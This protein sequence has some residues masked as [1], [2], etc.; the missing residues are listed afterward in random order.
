MTIFERAVEKFEENS[1]SAKKSGADRRKR[2]PDKMGAAESETAPPP[3]THAKEAARDSGR[4]RPLVQPIVDRLQSKGFLVPGG[5]E[6]RFMDEYRRIKQPLLA[7]AFGKNA[8]LVDD[9]NLVLVTSS[10]PKEG[11]SFTAINLAMTVAQEQDYTVLLVDCDVIRQDVSRVLGLTDRVGMLDVLDR[12]ELSLADAMW[13]TDV[14]DLVV[15]PAGRKT[16]NVTELVAS[17]RM[18]AMMEELRT[19]YP[20]RFIIMDS[21][22]LLATPLTQALVSFAGQVLMVVAAGE[23]PVNSVDEALEMVPK[24]KAVGM[25]LN[26]SVG[27]FRRYRGYYG[28]YYG[29]DD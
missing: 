21:P 8:P 2:A 20:D 12:N 25:V 6:F 1:G 23:T 13:R 24:G 15:I 19:R 16:Q 9:G 11:K 10:L 18:M 22:P 3:E 4:A 14:E 26:K 7:N 27:V 29:A 17:N 5:R 28:G